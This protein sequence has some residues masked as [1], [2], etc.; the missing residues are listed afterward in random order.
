MGESE[1]RPSA[2]PSFFLQG[3][4]LETEEAGSAWRHRVT[5]K[6]PVLSL[7][8]L[9][10]EFSAGTSSHL[11]IWAESVEGAE[12][13]AGPGHSVPPPWWGVGRWTLTEPSNVADLEVPWS[14]PR[15]R[16]GPKLSQATWPSAA[17]SWSWAQL[18]CPEAHRIPGAPARC[19]LLPSSP[20]PASL[21]IYEASVH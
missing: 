10:P 3:L 9:V 17:Q 20:A 7:E 1:N 19:P 6:G 5:S 11:C 8:P 21:D 14:C 16:G 4:Q 18:I 15:H 13:E 2:L 12:A